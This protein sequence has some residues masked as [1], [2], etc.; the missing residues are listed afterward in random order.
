MKLTNFG[1]RLFKSRALLSYND[2]GLTRHGTACYQ[3]TYD[4]PRPG[5]V[6]ALHA[7]TSIEAARLFKLLLITR[8]LTQ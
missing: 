4:L 1:F 5:T 8:R 7:G 3:F 2:F 6:V